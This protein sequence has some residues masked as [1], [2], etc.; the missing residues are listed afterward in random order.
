M[1]PYGLQAYLKTPFLPPQ[2]RQTNRQEPCRL[3]QGNAPSRDNPVLGNRLPAGTKALHLTSEPEPSA[4]ALLRYGW[5]YSQDH[6]SLPWFST[7][8][9]ETAAFPQIKSSQIPNMKQETKTRAAQVVGTG[10]LRAHVDNHWSACLEQTEGTEPW[11]ACPLVMP[12]SWAS[13]E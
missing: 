4:Q 3:D 2:R 1:D 5:V 12:G 8:L 11:A 13:G 7:L 6:D 9:K 10:F